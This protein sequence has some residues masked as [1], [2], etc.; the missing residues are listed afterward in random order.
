MIDGGTHA[1]GLTANSL[2]HRETLSSPH[3]TL[4]HELPPF[5]PETTQIMPDGAYTA[6]LHAPRIA[7]PALKPIP[8]ITLPPTVGKQ[9]L[10]LGRLRVSWR[11]VIAA[12]AFSAFE[13][14]LAR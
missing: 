8:R 9:S 5:D 14:A 12:T 7:L 2:V 4:L 1:G 6:L 3:N 11:P 13:R 10:R